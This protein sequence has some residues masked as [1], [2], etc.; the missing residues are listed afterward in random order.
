MIVH[1][2]LR[3]SRK[4]VVLALSGT[5]VAAL[6][7]GAVAIYLLETQADLKP[8]HEPVLTGEFSED[9]DLETFEDYL[10]LEAA[11]FAELDELIID[12]LDPQYH[13]PI[14]RYHRGSLSDPQNWQRNWN[15]SYR[16]ETAEPAAIFVLIHGMSDSPYS[17]RNL[18]A[19]LHRAGGEVIGLRLPGH[20]TIPAGLLEPTWQDMAAAVALAAKEAERHAKAAGGAAVYLVGY[21]IGAALAVHHALGAIEGEAAKVDGL[22]LLSPAIGLSALARLAPLQARMGRLFGLR[23]VAWNAVKLE[24]DPFKYGSF[25]INAATQSYR[26]TEEIK[27]DLDRLSARGAL[28][29]LPPILA[30]QSVADATVSAEAVIGNLFQ[31]LPQ[32][33][34]ELVLFDINRTTDVPSLLVEDPEPILEALLSRDALTFTLSLLTNRASGSPEVVARR[35]FPG[36][37]QQVEETTGLSWPA[38][39]FSLSHVALPFPASDA[40]YGDG[41]NHDSPGIEL[42]FLALRGERGLLRLS[43]GDML[44]LRWNPFYGY[45]EHRVLD[46]VRLDSQHSE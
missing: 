20:G 36:S 39:V 43:A 21:S 45:I 7:L 37:A 8:W 17:L 9:H 16:L 25:P 12:P 15:R 11:L 41:R 29:E 35:R 2:T 4:L 42:G 18:A 33:G 1:L 46:F 27:A 19:T 26:L 3:L 31:K 10:R 44:R 28:A 38:E 5:V 23:K 13:S 34:H 30:F 14:N 40:L 6:G 22:V 32:G 24:Y